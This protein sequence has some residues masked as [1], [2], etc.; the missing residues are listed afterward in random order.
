MA[1][2]E[3]ATAYVSLV[4]SLKGA[5][6]AIA[7]ELSGVDLKG[8]GSSMGSSLGGGLLGTFKGLVG[9]A[10]AV[11]GS[12]LFAGFI[13]DAARASDATDK[14]KSTM[15]FAGLDTS[16]IDAATKASKAY[17]DQTVYDLPT[18]QS[19]MA[20]LAA[21]GV[22]DYTSITT[23]AGNLN[24]VA[25]GNAETFQSVARSLTQS[26]GAG[27]LMTEDW[28]MLADAI[29][30][31]SGKLKES[32]KSAGAYT[33]DFKKAMEK[34]EITAEEFQAAVTELGS[35][36]VAVEAAKSV[37]TFEGSLGNLSATINSG[38]MGAL[39]AMKPQLTGI[40]NG[41][42]AG[43]GAAFAFTGS[44]ITGI[45]GILV[46]GDFTGA[47]TDAFGVEEDSPV[48]GGLFT[49]RETVIEVFGGIRDFIAGAGVQDFFSSIGAA[50]GPLI[51]HV[52][53]LW[54]ALSPLNL[55]FSALQPF[56]PPLLAM[57]GELAGVIGGTLITAITGILPSI[58]SLQTIFVSLLQGVI[59]QVLPVIVQLVT[60]LGQTFAQ[61]LPILVPIITQVMALAATLIAQ[62]VPIFM[63]LVTAVLPMVVTI[64]GAVLSAI[65]PLISMI[66]GLLIPI[67]MALMP[68]VV[69]IFGVIAN[70][71]TTV[72]QII[73]G[74][75]QV[76]TGIISGNW[77]QVWSGI[78]NIFSGIWNTIVA[79]LSGVFAIIWSVISSGL[80]LVF[81]FI[82]SVLGNIGRFFADTWNNITR[83]ISDFVGG[84]GRFFAG[85]PDAIMGALS[86]AG[87]WLYDAGKNIVEGLFNG[88]KSLAGTIGNF[89]LS[90]LPGWI[91]EPFKIALNIH[92][93][94]RVFREFG[95]NIGQ[96]L[97]LGVGDEQGAI[98]RAMSNLVTV[99]ELPAFATSGARSGYAAAA[100]PGDTDA[101][102]DRV[103][104]DV[105]PSEKMSEENLAE[106]M[107]RKLNG[108]LA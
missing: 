100:E 62:L 80:N 60:M 104:I 70:V 34:G 9:P 10:M 85:I 67:I 69:T 2:T 92:S 59:A 28:N 58:M 78:L 39:D 90:L 101:N 68:V 22:K 98:D 64:F 14:F 83:G 46:D 48:V 51:P 94:S 13:A 15:N 31:A 27:K 7:R 47:M 65:G 55:I 84:I 73:M 21:N 54:S 24:A 63:Q 79:V 41:V 74:V 8:A 93:P 17:A 19:T 95:V 30:G 3:L 49:I 97:L 36:P 53:G 18:I 23:A 89:F 37:T 35:Q 88:I 105:H 87:T 82:G 50:I 103:H 106:I 72:M 86:G 91:V 6:G 43:V 42:S 33:G 71:I 45:K 61:L 26:A 1:A 108:A 38:L 66:A 5:G 40:I 29:P 20:Q 25:G 44:A 32:M 76:V 56:L 96:G 99:P 57:F 81:G 11:L 75:I 16:A 102:G 52:I 77:G 107:A 4:P 12:G